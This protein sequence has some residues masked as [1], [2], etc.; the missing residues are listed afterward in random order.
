M[1]CPHCTRSFGQQVLPVHVKACA[2]KFNDSKTK[3]DFHKYAG[4]DTKSRPTPSSP[5]PHSNPRISTP[6]SCHTEDPIDID[7]FSSS[8]EENIIVVATTQAHEVELTIDTVQLSPRVI[9]EQSLKKPSTL[10]IPYISPTPRK[11]MEK[12][13]SSITQKRLYRRTRS[14]PSIRSV[15]AR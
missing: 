2:V 10:Y 15:F 5:E 9:F 8:E 13:S 6:D 12:T 11:T 3:F 7:R 4:K 14:A 1:D